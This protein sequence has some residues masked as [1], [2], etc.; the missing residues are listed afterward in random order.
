[1][2]HLGSAADL[3]RLDGGGQALVLRR[4]IGPLPVLSFTSRG[5]VWQPGSGFDDRVAA[6]RRARIHLINAPGD[7]TDVLRAAGYRQIL[8]PATIATLDL[9]ADA[10]LQMAQARMQWRNAARKLK[11]SG[12]RI[13]QPRPDPA[14]IGWLLTAETLQRRQK[15][16]R[17]W[18]PAVT[19]ALCLTSPAETHVFTANTGNT[20]HAALLFLR[21]GTAATYH[22]GWSDSIGRAA[23]A[24]H[25]LMLHAAN[26]LSSHGVRQID[27]GTVD[28]QNAPGLA[29]F[30]IGTGARI[31][32]LGG[33]WL[34]LLPRR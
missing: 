13:C 22:I 14:M 18:P 10:Q 25:A 9:Q 30:K 19:Q 17:A 27:L 5:P 21:H 29:R 24:H 4:K 16:Y 6:L 2:Q 20:P 26:W 33:T 3:V 31:A 8:S 7:D 34:R 12:L 23:S 1:V 28:T 11:H 15:S 32:P